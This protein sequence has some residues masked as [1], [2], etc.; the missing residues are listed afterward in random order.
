[1]SFDPV[2]VKAISENQPLHSY[3]VSQELSMQLR[4]LA[5]FAASVVVSF[6]SVPSALA[7]TYDMRDYWL[8]PQG[9]YTEL[10]TVFRSGGGCPGG[11]GVAQHAFWRGTL[12]GRTVALQGGT[13]LAQG[14]SAYDI[15]EE[16]GSTIAYWGTFRGNDYSLASP[17]SNSFSSPY[18]FMNNFMAVNGSTS[19][20]ITDNAM[21]NRLRKK[22]SSTSQMLSVAVQA[23]FATWT[24]PDSGTQ[25]SDVLKVLYTIGNRPETYY[26]ANSIGTVR[27]ESGDPNEPSCV[28]KQYATD[29][30]SYTQ[31]A[32]PLR[33]W[34]DPFSNNTYA[35]NGF[36]EDFLLTPV[37]GGAPLASYER[38]W[39]GN[40]AD[41]VLTN[42][43]GDPGT[44]PWKVAMR[45]ATGGGDSSADAAMSAVIP[46]VPNATYRLSGYLWR[47]SGSDRVY[48]DFND[49]PFDVDIQT[50]QT[51]AWQLVQDQVNVGVATSIRVRCLRDMANQGNA[52]C[53]GITLQRVD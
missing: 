41:V 29:V 11:T 51:N 53:D 20:T 45:G 6:A 34:Y 52:Y 24:D 40:S 21:D 36:F 8:M 38:S 18:T 31:S 44:S 30:L 48:I 2:Y 5:I 46:V 4:Q 25:W 12:Q 27:F 39:S 1:M 37:N 49:A 33:P 10:F 47:T 28:I 16:T 15:F 26:L 17:T 50:S 9:K 43:A 35:P 22:V 7:Q 3:P 14:Y 13:D 42:D 32:S 19:G 23:H